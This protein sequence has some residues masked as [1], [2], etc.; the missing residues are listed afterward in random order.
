MTCFSSGGGGG[1]LMSSF[2]PCS[3][4]CPG[5]TGIPELE[6]CSCHSL[7]HPVCVGIPQSRNR[8]NNLVFMAFEIAN[9]FII[10]FIIYIS[11]P[12]YFISFLLHFTFNFFFI[13]FSHHFLFLIISIFFIFTNRFNSI[14]NTTQYC[15]L[16]KSGYRLYSNCLPLLIGAYTTDQ[17]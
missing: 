11:F 6:C 5:V 17:I 12:F 7:F 8:E 16:K 3:P 1:G 9:L 4:F 14:I 2:T 13:S 15:T 10:S